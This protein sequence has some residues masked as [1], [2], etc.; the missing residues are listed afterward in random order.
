[1]VVFYTGAVDIRTTQKLFFGEHTSYVL[2]EKGE[3]DAPGAIQEHL[4]R[5]SAL[6]DTIVFFDG[7]PGEI[8]ESEFHEVESDIAERFPIISFCCL[9]RLTVKKKLFGGKKIGATTVAY[10]A[11]EY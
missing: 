2:Y 10:T 8:S 9:C 1:M 4:E 5:E 7:Y 6:E 11:R 3:T